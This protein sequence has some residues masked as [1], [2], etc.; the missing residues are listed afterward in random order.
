MKRGWVEW[1]LVPLKVFVLL[2]LCV[3][4]FADSSA[5]PSVPALDMGLDMLVG[6]VCLFCSLVFTGASLIQRSFGPEGAA[7]RSIVFAVLAFIIGAILSPL[8]AVA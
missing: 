3:V 5:M 8:F 1:S 6:W 4:P 7:R 2:A